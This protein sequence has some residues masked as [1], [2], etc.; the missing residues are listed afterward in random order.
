MI[1]VYKDIL[2]YVDL[3]KK[4]NSLYTI[5]FLNKYLNMLI[6]IRIKLLNIFIVYIE[7]IEYFQIMTDYTF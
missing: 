5:Y 7:Y 4:F 2:T 6:I 1:K 3:T